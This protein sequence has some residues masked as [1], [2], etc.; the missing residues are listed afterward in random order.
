MKGLEYLDVS[1][2]AMTSECLGV[3]AEQISGNTCTIGLCHLEAVDMQVTEE[4]ALETLARAISKNQAERGPTANI[5]KLTT[6]PPNYIEEDMAPHTLILV[7]ENGTGVSIPP[8]R[9]GGGEIVVGTS[10]HLKEFMLD[11]VPTL[12]LPKP[13]EADH[14]QSTVYLR[15]LPNNIQLP[16]MEVELYDGLVPSKRGKFQIYTSA[17]SVED[18]VD[19]VVSLGLCK[20]QTMCQPP[21]VIQRL[22]EK[23]PNLSLTKQE[24]RH[25]YPG[26]G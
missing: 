11:K 9:Y 26:W 14:Y 6:Y 20:F 23:L 15:P 25:Y 10:T 1:D 12:F 18:I 19:V 16:G 17:E 4:S 24:P 13:S 2:N 8:P 21:P 7:P 22:Q 5:S 3:L